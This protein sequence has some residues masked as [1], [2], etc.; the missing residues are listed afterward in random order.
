MEPGVAI[1][2]PNGSSASVM[3]GTDSSA[4]SLTPCERTIPA[5]SR[6]PKYPLSVVKSVS[7]RRSPGAK[8]CWTVVSSSTTGAVS[9]ATWCSFIKRCASPPSGSTGTRSCRRPTGSTGSVASN[10]KAADDPGESTPGSANTVPAGPRGGC[11]CCRVHKRREVRRRRG[12]QIERCPGSCTRRKCLRCPPL[13]GPID[14]VRDVR[15]GRGGS[16]LDVAVEPRQREFMS[17][18][19]TVG[20]RS[21]TNSLSS[22]PPG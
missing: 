19:R 5:A 20:G 22:L 17:S 16:R 6:D 15:Y 4:W 9:P 14:V 13:V 18:E 1:T 11:Q 2:S 8:P 12:R 7:R 3:S 10:A 21:V